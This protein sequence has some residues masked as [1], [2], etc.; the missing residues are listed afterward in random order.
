MLIVNKH[1]I[2]QNQISGYAPAHK[3]PFLISKLQ[4]FP[5]PN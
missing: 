3:L 4:K 5:P 1:L 2:P